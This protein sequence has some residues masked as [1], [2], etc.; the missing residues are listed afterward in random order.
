MLVLI[1]L[2]CIIYAAYT[3]QAMIGFG[4]NIIAL[5]LGA[6]FWPLDELLPIVVALNIPLSGWLVWRARHAVAGRLLVAQI[7]PIAGMGFVLGALVSS[8]LRSQW[9]AVG[10]GALV[11]VIALWES[12]RA[13]QDP[14]PI[15]GLQR[16]LA[17][18]I[19][20]L[21]QGLYASG[22]PFIAYAMGRM[23]L[24]RQSFRASLLSIWLVTNSVLFASFAFQG[25]VDGRTWQGIA[26]ALPLIW[27]GLRSGDWLHHHVSDITFRRG[28]YA[29]LVIA[30]I[31][32]TIRSWPGS[33]VAA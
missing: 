4:A 33:V 11:T 6:Q 22:G 30:G 1:L 9:L 20:G 31:I 5:S 21:A 2:G 32:L 24:S 3:T 19:G 7:L 12:A 29:V 14:L 25:R 17:L 16:W 26:C 23:E 18:S 13:H 15:R 27:L 8:W 10:Y 28:V